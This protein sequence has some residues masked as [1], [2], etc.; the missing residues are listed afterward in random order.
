MRVSVWDTYVKRNDGLTMHFDILVPVSVQDE[1]KIV[2]FGKQYLH[3]KSFGTGDL[4]S[5]EC[6]FCHIEN[7]S[8]DIIK[9][10]ENFGFHIIEMEHCH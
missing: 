7:A 5:K 9:N 3:Q 2:H 6:R 8:E 1:D 4:T 10:I